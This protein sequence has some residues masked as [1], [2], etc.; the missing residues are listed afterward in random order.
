MGGGGAVLT[1]VRGC[2]D[3]SET[4]GKTG[5]KKQW[6]KTVWNK[7]KGKNQG[8]HREK[9]TG[10]MRDWQKIQV[11]WDGNKNWCVVQRKRYLVTCWC[12]DRSDTGFRIL[13][14]ES[15]T[16]NSDSHGD[17]STQARIF[18]WAMSF[19]RPWWLPTSQRHTDCIYR[20]C[21]GI[22]WPSLALPTWSRSITKNAPYA[23]GNFHACAI[24]RFQKP[25]HLGR[26]RIARSSI[27][28]SRAQRA[29]PDLSD[30]R[31]CKLRL[32]LL[33]VDQL[34]KKTWKLI[35][36][37][38]TT[39]WLVCKYGHSL[40]EPPSRVFYTVSVSACLFVGERFFQKVYG[41]PLPSRSPFTLFAR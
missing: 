26:V 31:C 7:T 13:E 27:A 35:I 24:T 20:L 29:E 9:Q 12:W 32:K 14:V 2:E 38:V 36:E 22:P 3:W 17:T 5:K 37:F 33:L 34:A 8:K 30:Q 1:G 41:R 23:W 21:S 19:C 11:N 28:T 4:L 40:L 16:D 25:Q 18:C 15:F 6:E 10:V 39:K